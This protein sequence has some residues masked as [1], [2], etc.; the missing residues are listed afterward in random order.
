MLTPAGR[1]RRDEARK[2]NQIVHLIS[3]VA[4]AV[5]VLPRGRTLTVVDCGCG[6]SQLLFVLNHVMTEG[7][8]LRAHFVGL[9]VSDRAVATARDLQA[10][11]GYLNM[12]F[13]ATPIRT[14][15]PPDKLDAVLSLHACDTA[16]DEAIALGIGAGAPVVIAVPCCQAELARQVG[17]S[18]G[19]GDPL[20]RALRHGA[21]RRRF[22]DWMTD[23][24]RALYLEASGYGVDVLEYVSPLDTPKNIML[25]ARRG[26]AGPRDREAAARSFE[27]ICNQYGLD[28]SLPRLS[29]MFRGP[30]AFPLAAPNHRPSPGSPL[31]AG[32]AARSGRDI[33]P[34]SCGPHL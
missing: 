32:R 29:K 3:L 31:S 25:R 9:D 10:K 24:L 30:V 20:R 18:G 21:L 22:G 26:A 1:I 14:W 2:Y 28:P 11:L 16:T 33:R 5:A 6:K 7:F 8:G 4:D 13:M 19:S 23:A 15:D 34:G 17:G 12:E 27:A